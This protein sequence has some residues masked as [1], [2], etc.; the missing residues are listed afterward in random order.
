MVQWKEIKKKR[1]VRKTEKYELWK[2]EE[3]KKRNIDRWGYR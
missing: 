3:L 1:K 2:Y